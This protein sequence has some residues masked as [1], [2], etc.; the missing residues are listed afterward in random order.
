ME[1]DMSATDIHRDMPVTNIYHNMFTTYV[2][3]NM[4]PVV[5]GTGLLVHPYLSN[6][7]VKGGIWEMCTLKEHIPWDFGSRHMDGSVRNNFSINLTRWS[8]GWPQQSM[9]PIT[10]QQ[11]IP[12][13]ATQWLFCQ[14]YW[15]RRVLKQVN[16]PQRWYVWREAGQAVQGCLY[17]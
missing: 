3:Y 5:K 8:L 9:K 1:S 10:W 4:S 11:T 12:K 16:V 17:K 6:T 14:S 2:Y 13:Y 7:L 15:G